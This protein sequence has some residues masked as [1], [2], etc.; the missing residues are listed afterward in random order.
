[1]KLPFRETKSNTAPDEAT[2]LDDDSSQASSTVSK[3]EVAKHEQLL[4]WWPEIGAISSSFAFLA[5]ILV[6]LSYIEGTRSNDRNV[7]WQIR[8]ITVASTLSTISRLALLVAIAE[9]TENKR[10]AH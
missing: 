7:P 6:F 3:R 8:P 1:M 4:M 9:C 2:V 10:L 5:A